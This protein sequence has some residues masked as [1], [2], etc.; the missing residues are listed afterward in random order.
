MRKFASALS[1]AEIQAICGGEY[2]GSDKL[3]AASVADPAEAAADSV[4]Y[5]EQPRF[6]QT[7][8]DSQAGLIICAPDQAPQLPGRNLL[9]HPRPGLAMLKLLSWWLESSAEKP[10]PG[11]HPTAV[12]C[13]GAEIGADAHIGAF[14][15]L[16]PNC[17]I[18]TG[19]V[20]EAHCAIG[21]QTTVG[22][23]T[24]LYP[25]VTL[26]PRSVIGADCI[27]HS[28]AV[29]GADGFGF[30]LEDGVQQKIPQVGNVVIGDR[31]EIGANTAV[32]RGTLGPTSIGEGTKIDNLVQIGHNCRIGK[33]CILCAQVG[34]AGSTVLGDHVY[35]AGKSGSA[36][37]LSIGDR[38]MVGAQGGV[39]HDL[40]ADGL[41]WGTPAID[42]NIYKR[43]LA[44]QRKLPEIYGHYRKQIKNDED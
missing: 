21:P 1:G 25:R 36:G 18:G 19:A 43:I 13:P 14:C 5:C 9:L 38:A 23:N 29:I 12:V 3:Q 15:V 6:F 27:I 10:P 35:M 7:V 42:A 32:D 26:Y 41:Y 22:Q 4:V 20:I 16:G 37:H 39:T 33:H 17:R 28:G 44:L 11:I 40:P 24:W 2:R 31:V 34:L 8:R 30:V